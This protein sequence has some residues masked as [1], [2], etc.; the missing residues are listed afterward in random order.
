MAF[1]PIQ[2]ERDLA[3]ESAGWDTTY[4]VPAEPGD[5]PIV[6][7]A[8]YF[9]T[10]DQ[11][12]LD[13]AA[14]S[15]RAAAEDVGFYYLV[16]HG[17]SVER[18]ALLFDQVTA[19]HALPLAVK[20]S[21]LMDRPGAIPGSGYLGL[22]NRK[23]PSRETTNSNEA[24][25]FKSGNGLTLTDNE[26]LS[27]DVIPGFREAVEDYAA[28]VESIALRLLPVYA[29]AL[30]LDAQFFATAFLEPLWRLRLTHYPPAESPSGTGAETF[31][32]SPH[33]DTTFFTMLLQDSPGL[34]VYSAART[35]WIDAPMVDGAF[36]VNSGEL[37]RQWSND[38]FLSTRHFVRPGRE[39]RYSIPFFWNATAD[40]RM[41]CLPTCTSVSN[42]PRY[43]AFSYLESQGVIQ[44]E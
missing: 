34:T 8:E 36:V 22:G 26:W 42:P 11:H 20:E 33:V 17:L 44:G 43:P 10:G 35:E 32:I 1:D 9:A 41:E 39:H 5:I 28:V 38:R 23:L 37:L 25:V 2:K 15:L 18:S 31:G 30:E 24:V 40:F 3:T 4:S 16:G 21:L 7:V 6:D 12:A 27:E 29:T 13:S 14:S 19:F